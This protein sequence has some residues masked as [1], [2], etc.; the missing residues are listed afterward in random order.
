MCGFFLLQ[1]ED[2]HEDERSFRFQKEI[3]VIFLRKEF[4]FL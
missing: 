2:G 3:E 4:G 1:T